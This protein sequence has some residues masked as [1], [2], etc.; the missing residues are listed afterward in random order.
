MGGGASTLLKVD[1]IAKTYRKGKPVLRGIDLSVMEGEIVG[2]VGESGSGKSTLTRIIM[3][4]ETPQSGFVSFNGLPVE[5]SSRKAFYKD[6]Q[7]IFQN[8]SASF[9][10][11]WTIQE[12]LS[13]PLQSRK[14]NRL[15][16]IRSMLSKVNLNEAH[17]RRLP[18]EL[19]GGEKQRV[20]L[21]RAILVEPKLLICDEIVSNLDKLIQKEII[22]LLIKLKLE[23]NLSILFIS[24]DLRVVEYMCDR[25]LV[26]KDGEIVD[27]STK[28]VNKFNFSHPYS[29]KLFKSKSNC[30]M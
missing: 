4:L 5:K 9:N 19:S 20:N 25:I 6:C 16:F 28:I 17:L 1:N 12:I 14:K 13:E 7:L 23:T 3:Q 24:H 18:S 21:L 30:E 2:I 10:P 15:E 27:E 11:S 22:D 29:K 26:M 8:A